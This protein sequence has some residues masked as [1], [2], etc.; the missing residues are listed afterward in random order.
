MEIYSLLNDYS[1]GAHP[2]ILQKLSE[3]NNEQ[4]AG[5]GNDE[6]SQRAKELLKVKIEDTKADIHFVSGGTQ[7]NI[8]VIAAALRPYESVISAESGHI[9]FHEAGAIEATGHKIN[10]II[11]EDGKISPEDI[12]PIMIKHDF[13]P[14]VVKPAMVYISNTTELGTVYKK[15]EL[16]NLYSLCKAN[17]LL[18]FI[19][20]A[21]MGT[22][23]TSQNSELSLKIIAKNSDAFTIGG[24]KNGA[25]LGEAIVITNE[26]LKKD[27]HYHLKQ[28]GA[29]LSKGRLLGIQ[30]YE[31]FKPICILNL[32]LT[33]IKM[34]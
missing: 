18:L 15:H 16:E 25:L 19:D 23:I 13:A 7:A 11:K 20:G 34:Q 28:K 10:A 29:L 8:L 33:Q 3:T 30:F 14:H 9:N 6:Y 5:Y 32:Q 27:F 24:T 21:R 22:A 26:Y 31:L 12:E 2:N 17:N 1:E 4:Q